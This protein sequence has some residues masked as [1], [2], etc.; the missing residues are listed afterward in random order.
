MNEG[1]LSCERGAWLRCVLRV[2]CHFF[3]VD[4]VPTVTFFRHPEAFLA[5]YN[6]AAQC[7]GAPNGS[8][9]SLLCVVQEALFAIIGRGC[10]WRRKG[11]CKRYSAANAVHHRELHHSSGSL[12]LP[13]RSNSVLELLIRCN[14]F[15][16]LCAYIDSSFP[17]TS[18]SYSMQAYA[19]S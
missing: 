7:A 2:S 16:V 12:R 4:V 5:T 13:H 17:L 9:W 19:Y 18:T 15:W 3:C 1:Y 10:A 14:A 8:I 11:C 6:S